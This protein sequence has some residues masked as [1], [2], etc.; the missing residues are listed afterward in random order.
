MNVHVQDLD[1]KDAEVR[2]A[3]LAKERGV[4]TP[5]LIQQDGAPSQSLMDFCS[6]YGLTLD[7]VVTGEGPVYRSQALETPVLRLY[8]QIMDIREAA[9]TYEPKAD[10]KA[11]EDEV[12]RLFWA[13][14]AKLERQMMALPSTCAADFAAKA[15]VDSAEGGAL[16]D[17]ETGAFSGIPAMFQEWQELTDRLNAMEDGPES[18]IVFKRLTATMDNIIAATPR[19]VHD[20]AL[21][22]LVADDRGDMNMNAW[23]E[24]LVL[25]AK[26]LT[27]FPRD[28]QTATAADDPLPGLFREWEQT[29]DGFNASPGDP[30]K[31]PEA[32]RLYNR[33]HELVEQMMRTPP[34]SPAGAAAL[35]D[36]LI[37]DEF[38]ETSSYNGAPSVLLQNLREYLASRDEADEEPKAAALALKPKERLVLDDQASTLAYEVASIID[39]C[40]YAHENETTATPHD[41]RGIDHVLRIASAKAGNLIE[42]VEHLEIDAR[43]VTSKG[44]EH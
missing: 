3:A 23:Q 37:A 7:F 6:T 16:T 38:V 26:E 33:H 30:D 2:L 18:N 29:R 24:A 28:R 32:G 39:V 21:K 8:R 12:D 19:S 35:V 1:H 43:A 20:M 44:G 42:M 10:G 34:V 17:W 15:I 31:D 27:G 41:R 5:A 36:L 14:A 11:A 9:K 25:Q 40:R 13:P 22:V 4:D